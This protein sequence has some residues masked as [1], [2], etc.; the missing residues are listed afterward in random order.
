M[1]NVAAFLSG[2]AGDPSKYFFEG[3]ILEKD[4]SAYLR[5]RSTE[6]Q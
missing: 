5:N 4:I 6:V 1:K 2:K 3:Q